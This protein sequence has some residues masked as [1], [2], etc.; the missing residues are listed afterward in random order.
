MT[1]IEDIKDRLRIEDEIGAVVKLRRAGKNYTGMCPFHDNSH[2]PAFV[3]FPGTQSW[4]CFGQCNEGG[5]IFAFVMKKNGWDFK[6]ALRALAEKAGVELRP[7]GPE[8]QKRVELQRARESVFGVAVGYFQQSLKSEMGKRGLAYAHEARCWPDELLQDAGV[9]YFGKDWNGLR[10]ALTAAGIDLES[11]AAVA[12]VGFR[13]D[14]LSWAKKHG[15][16][17]QAGH[18]WVDAKKVP[19]M[20][21]D[22]LI[23]PHMVHGRVVTIAGRRLPDPDLPPDPLPEGKGESY[24]PKSWNPP[25]ELVGEKQP[26]FNQVWWGRKTAGDTAKDK[27]KTAEQHQV[28][29]AVI[30]EGQGDAVTLGHWDLMAVALVGDAIAGY[31]PRSPHFQKTKMEGG[32]QSNAGNFLLSELKRKAGA[33]L[34][35]V[36]GLDNDEDGLKKRGQVVDDLMA[37]G[38]SVT[39]ICVVTWPFKDANE[40]LTKGGTLKDAQQLVL[41]AQPVLGLMIDD[42]APVSGTRDDDAVRKLFGALTKLTSFEVENVREEVCDRLQIRHRMFDGLLKAARRDAGQ[43]DDGQARYFIE[44][45][46][47]FARFYDA[48]GGESIDPLCNFAA[49]IK[50]DV[51]RDNGQETVREFRI[52]GE[53]GKMPLPEARV[54]ADEFSKMDWVLKAWGSR[55]IIE[56][57]SR[58]KD[59]LRAAI[60]HLSREVERRT[61]Y[62]H[63]GWRSMSGKRIYLSA[64]GAVGAEGVDVELDQDLELYNIPATPDDAEGAMRLSLSFLDIAPDHISFPIWSAVWLPVMRELVNVAFVMWVFGGTG[65]M[66]STYTALAMNHYGPGFDDKHLPANFLDTANRL[67]QKSFVIKD[68]VLVIDDYAPQKDARSHSDYV[69]AAARIIRAAG[70][71]SGR[72]RLTADASART[73]YV[74]RS[75]GVITGEDLIEL[76]GLVARLVVVERKRGEIDKEKL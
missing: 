51:L 33:G 23:Y 60:Q 43:N 42:A 55:T 15:V 48:Q 14:V 59:Q 26:F 16:D 56:A 34:K 6:E 2:T 46:R 24:I 45:G 74:P 3:V 47:I 17:V 19:A 27:K 7:M 11:P 58:R 63:T 28:D 21:P 37:A 8:E 73:T 52:A 38:L 9:G 65:A 67:E 31:P 44:G 68:A 4:K 39:Q 40:W 29:A 57:G 1:V 53:S 32:N 36:V 50:E 49:T 5:D 54:P 10:E 35:I 25:V 75:R 71:L 61:I 62:T 22:M 20:P 64:A 66:K 76:E 41:L 18:P 72:G 13:G 69:R 30:V 70:N 12:L